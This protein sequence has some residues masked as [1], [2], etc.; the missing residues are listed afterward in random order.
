[1]CV[2][3]D[4]A[5][6]VRLTDA[7]LGVGLDE[8]AIRATLLAELAREGFVDAYYARLIE[9]AA[10]ITI[11]RLPPLATPAGKVLPYHLV[12]RAREANYA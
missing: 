12:R 10:S 7:L 5:G 11:K 6:T 3:F 9:R 8:A 4:A 2:P 1:M